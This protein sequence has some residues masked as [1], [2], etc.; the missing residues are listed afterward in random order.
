MPPP[1]LIL[2]RDKRRAIVDLER[3][4]HTEPD[5]PAVDDCRDVIQRPSVEVVL[6]KDRVNVDQVIDCQLRTDSGV[7]CFNRCVELNVKLVMSGKM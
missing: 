7:P 2:R 5:H 3:N 1:L 6:H 4:V